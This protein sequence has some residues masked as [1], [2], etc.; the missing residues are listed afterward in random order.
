M[1]PPQH[2]AIIMDGNG[3]WAQSRNLARREGHKEGVKT[4]KKIVKH[5]A[6]QD[7]SSLTV[8]AFS[9]EN[10]KR[11]KAEVDFLL[12]LMKRTMRREVKELL[13]NGVRVNF[14]GRKEGLS[15]NLIK[16]IEKIEK[17]SENNKRLTLNIA[18][19]YGG[20]AEI[21]DAA[22]KII[23]EAKNND[24]ALDELDEDKFS[25]YLYNSQFKDIELLIRTGGDKRLSNFLLW[26]SAYAELYFTN[27]YWP[28]FDETELDAALEDFQNRERKFG[29]LNDGDNNA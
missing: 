18:F 13:D 20:R 17:Q 21:V 8:Y 16:E 12:A 28:D 15:K 11:P 24:F 26:Q 29:G 2:I 10:W 3:R 27:T 19:N 9:T 4:L 23:S 25:S 5:A 7:I 14:I 22:K 6:D 1:Y